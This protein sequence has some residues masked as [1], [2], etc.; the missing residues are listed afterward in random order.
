MVFAFPIIPVD[1]NIKQE[2]ITDHSDCEKYSEETVTK[3]RIILVS[4]VVLWI[5]L[6][7]WLKVIRKDVLI[8]VFIL[9]PIVLAIVGFINAPKIDKNCEK[10]VL[11]TNV[12]TIGI[13]AAAI[14]SQWNH[15]KNNVDKREF[16]KFLA[17]AFVLLMI[18]VLDVW[19]DEEDR[20]LITHAKVS[21]Q[22]ISITLLIIAVYLLFQKISSAD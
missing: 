10:L 18:S 14:I 12:V 13:L 20:T 22:G 11:R 7:I 2:R 15:L 9:I 8:I 19:A 4:S 1:D 3:I 21:I 6:V 5:I 16:Y 17:T